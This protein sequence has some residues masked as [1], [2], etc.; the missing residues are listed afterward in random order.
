MKTYEMEAPEFGPAEGSG[1]GV[2]VRFLRTQ[3]CVKSQCMNMH[4]S[5]FH[6]PLRVCGDGFLWLASRLVGCGVRRDFFKHC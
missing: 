2:R 3:Q 4:T 6:A 5:V 1:D